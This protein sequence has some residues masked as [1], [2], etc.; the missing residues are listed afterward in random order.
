[1]A[2]TMY[3]VGLKAPIG[4]VPKVAQSNMVA[5]RLL[6]TGDVASQKPVRD[7]HQVLKILKYFVEHFC[8]DHMLVW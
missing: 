6:S 2:L 7:T 3:L 4:L 1:M 8:I 5:I